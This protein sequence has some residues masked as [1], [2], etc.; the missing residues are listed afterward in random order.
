MNVAYLFPIIISIRTLSKVLFNFVVFIYPKALH[1]TE[2]TREKVTL[3]QA[4]VM[5]VQSKGKPKQNKNIKS[6]Y[7]SANRLGVVG[8]RLSIFG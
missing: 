2:T 6:Q 4:F 7:S 1:A 8:R 5:A 3:Y